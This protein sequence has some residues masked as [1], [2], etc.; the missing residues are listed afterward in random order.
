LPYSQ[1]R[2]RN[3]R[4]IWGLSGHTGKKWGNDDEQ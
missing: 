4:W 2:L 1:S 3:S